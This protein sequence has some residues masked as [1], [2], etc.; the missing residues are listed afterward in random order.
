MFSDTMAQI[1]VPTGGGVASGF[2]PPIIRAQG[3]ILYLLG[4]LADPDVTVSTE[5]A[6]A[7]LTA[8]KDHL[9]ERTATT[10]ISTAASVLL[11][12]WTMAIGE[13]TAEY[14]AWTDEARIQNLRAIANK[15]VGIACV[16]DRELVG[17]TGSN[18]GHA[19]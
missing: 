11:G 3:H 8:A 18:P 19:L 14:T 12:A 15:V 5:D 6:I 2:L 17:L 16:L 13:A 9:D 4:C 10:A 7:E 1:A